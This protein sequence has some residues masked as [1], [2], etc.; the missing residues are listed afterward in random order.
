MRLTLQRV[1]SSEHGIFG[2]LYTESRSKVAVTLEHA[3]P[4]QEG[5]VPKIPPG[6]YKCVRGIH[7][8]HSNPDSF[9]TFE[10]EGVAG[11]SNL[12]FHVGNYNHD[13]DGCVLLGTDFDCGEKPT[14]IWGS[15]HA[16]YGFM[17]FLE[18][19]TEFELE[20]SDV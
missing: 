17:E 15:R 10:I 13:F 11:H 7:R 9:Q 20:V 8:L 19:Q 5:F 16:F 14:Q 3:Y 1:Y 6:V 4:A 18:T 12:L 2:V